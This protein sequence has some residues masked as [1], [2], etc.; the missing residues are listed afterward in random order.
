MGVRHIGIA[1]R[2]LDES[3]R[4]YRDGLGCQI[5]FDQAAQL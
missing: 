5:V 1:V 4:F 3:L 2:D